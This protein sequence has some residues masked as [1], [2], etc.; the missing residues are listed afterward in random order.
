MCVC[1]C[2]LIFFVV[3]VVV[4]FKSEY[5]QN[6]DVHSMIVL[7]IFYCP[8]LCYHPSLSPYYKIYN[9]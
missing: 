2:V 1:V 8:L 9:K 3:V 7:H 5:K 6:G 4:V